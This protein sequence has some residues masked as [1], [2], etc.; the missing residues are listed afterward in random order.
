MSAIDALRSGWGWTLI[1]FAEIHAVSQMGHLLF[2][3]TDGCFH[4]LDPDLGR[5][6]ALG[7]E[8]AARTHFAKEETREVWQAIALV[9][10][11]RERLGDCPEGSVYTLKPLAL[12]EGDYSPDNLWIC[13]LDE[14]IRFTGDMARQLKDLP[15]GAQYRIVIDE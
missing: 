6:E 5:I 15:D 12:L 14:L 1:E 3:D 8:Q 11:A 7:N 13:Q 2:S 10:A 9:E 4:Y